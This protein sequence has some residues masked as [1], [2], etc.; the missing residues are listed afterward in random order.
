LDT[1]TLFSHF[2]KLKTAGKFVNKIRSY[3]LQ[4]C[5]CPANLGNDPPS[6]PF[7]KSAVEH[8]GS[9]VVFGREGTQQLSWW[10]RHLGAQGRGPAAWLWRSSI[11][12]SFWNFQR[13][14]KKS[15]KFV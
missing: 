14:Q 10:A 1:F 8:L 6:S 2:A 5:A 11:Y 9:L 4:Y 7:E 15:I 12:T 3:V 13:G